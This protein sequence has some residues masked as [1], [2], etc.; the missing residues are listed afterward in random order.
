MSI[1]LHQDELC[2][3]LFLYIEKKKKT[4]KNICQILCYVSVT[5]Y[6]RF[7]LGV[8]FACPFD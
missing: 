1:N 3:H 4:N 5:N 8:N 7:C 2:V 6:V